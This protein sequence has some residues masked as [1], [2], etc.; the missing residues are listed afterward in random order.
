MRGTPAGNLP[1]TVF[2][3]RLKSCYLCNITIAQAVSGDSP[4]A[5]FL[6]RFS[7]L[8]RSFPFPLSPSL[9][10]FYTFTVISFLF[11]GD[12]LCPYD[13]SKK[14]GHTKEK[15]REKGEGDGKRVPEGKPK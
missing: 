12:D 3:I 4:H 14:S 6:L 2:N 5:L 15:S 11:M 10:D 13:R 8:K 9:S 1:S 7:S